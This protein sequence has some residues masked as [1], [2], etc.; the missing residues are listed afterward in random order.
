MTERTVRAFLGFDLPDEVRLTTARL[1]TLVGDRRQAV[2]WVKGANIHLTLRFLGATPE[3]TVAEIAAA[4]ESKLTKFP[5]LAVQVA[6]TGVFPAATRP[7]ILWLGVVGQTRE[8]KELEEVVHG[9]V[10]PMGFPRE[11]RDFSPHITIGRVRYP[12]KITPDVTNFL[13][14]EYSP[15]EC[16]LRTLNLYESRV[17]GGGVAYTPLASIRLQSSDEEEK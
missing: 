13:K 3:Q 6:E 16:P 17:A 2:R 12:Q 15:V 5:S 4:L 1:R 9:V 11:Q 8:L 7:R 10:G 14:A